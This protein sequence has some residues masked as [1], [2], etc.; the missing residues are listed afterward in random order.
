[1]VAEDICKKLCA[2]TQQSDFIPEKFIR[3]KKNK[4]QMVLSFPWDK[5][6]IVLLPGNED[7][8]KNKPYVAWKLK[9][10]R[11]AAEVECYLTRQQESSGA[12]STYQKRWETI[13]LDSGHPLRVWNNGNLGSYRARST[14][15]H[16]N[17]AMATE[18]KGW[19]GASPGMSHWRTHTVQ[20]RSSFAQNELL[21][22]RGLE[23]LYGSCQ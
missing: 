23:W 12:G 19:A 9:S 6:I 7:T 5:S 15:Q 8:K 2:L 1:M 13:E 18:P 3:D 21:H 16:Q 14:K 11:G 17:R 4:I 10:L 22:T 20:Q